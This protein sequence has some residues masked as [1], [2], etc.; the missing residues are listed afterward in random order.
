MVLE[1]FGRHSS[2]TAARIVG[3]GIRSDRSGG[4]G[5][6]V[7]IA[8]A[9]AAAGVVKGVDGRSIEIQHVGLQSQPQHRR[10]RL[11]TIRR[12]RATE[13]SRVRAANFSST[14]RGEAAAQ[15]RVFEQDVEKRGR[16]EDACLRIGQTI[17]R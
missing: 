4:I 1:L 11:G 13:K 12:R 5:T 8:A 15:R 3:A 10:R 7:V 17:P 14:K 6:A 2:S 9:A 16:E